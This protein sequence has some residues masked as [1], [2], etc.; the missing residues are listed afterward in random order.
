MTEKETFSKIA[1]RVVEQ[2]IESSGY[3]LDEAQMKRLLQGK[4]DRAR[5]MVEARKNIPAFH[6]D[7]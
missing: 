6:I 4:M 5:A 7:Y 2:V 3:H 1:D